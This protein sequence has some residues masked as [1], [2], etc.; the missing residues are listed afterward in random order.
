MLSMLIFCEG[1]EASGVPKLGRALA[2]LVPGVVRGLV[3]DVH[4][5]TPSALA[6]AALAEEAGVHHY[7]GEFERA[8]GALKGP[9]CMALRGDHRVD[10][11]W[12]DALEA[13]ISEAPRMALLRSVPQN[14]AQHLLPRL[15]PVS[16]LV[17][18]QSQFAGPLVASWADLRAGLRPRLTLSA[19]THP[20]A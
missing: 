15:A 20:I 18:H 16:G 7:V 4:V 5:V 10:G 9:W 8:F 17:W 19:R 3:G 11:A 14:I 13:F 12:F 6:Y 1:P 2:S